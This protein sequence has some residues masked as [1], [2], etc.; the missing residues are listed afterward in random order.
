MRKERRAKRRTHM[1]KGKS[2]DDE[3]EKERRK[4]EIE[5]KMERNEG[6]GREG[7]IICEIVFIQAD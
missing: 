5:K 1:R 2:K 6:N 7:R 4:A 3:W